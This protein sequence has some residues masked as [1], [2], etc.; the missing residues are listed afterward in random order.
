M[1]T[2]PAVST[3]TKRNLT[4]TTPSIGCPIC[5]DQGLAA[6]LSAPDRFHLRAKKYTL[7]RCAACGV[8]R[9]MNPPRPEEMGAHYTEDYH[10]AIAAAGETSVSKRWK[11]QRE[12]ISKYKPGGAI[13]D[14][15]C[16]SGGFLS[17]LDTSAWQLYG[18][19]MEPSTGER[20]R[21]LAG[22]QVWVGDVLDANFEPNSFD[23][24]TCFDLLEHIYTPREF[25]VQVLK[26]LK[27]GGVFYTVLPNIE[28]WEARTF[29]TYWYG[30]ELPRH[31]FHFS[32]RSLRALTASIGFEEVHIGTPPIS[33]V[34]RSMGY[35]G[36]GLLER[37]GF[38]PT[39]QANQQKK[40]PFAWRIVRKG[41]R[42]TFVRPLAHLASLSGAGP[43]M[44][45]VF[46]K[47]LDFVN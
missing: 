16:S 37:L 32:P 5:G 13:L 45:G 26:W 21:E 3:V 35:V 42:L 34:E 19:E 43:S 24:I 31:F 2:A 15:G 23:V 39:P 9:L 46:S 7:A 1:S 47:P 29:R 38:S 12:R 30:L 36:A 6:F 8:V 10:R 4:A 20:A 44:E 27:P 17:T 22:A 14:I 28:S 40:S 33:Y 25:L 18:I 41:L 11:A